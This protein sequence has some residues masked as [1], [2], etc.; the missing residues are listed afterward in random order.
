MNIHYLYS[1]EN[2]KDY[3]TKTIK[4]MY[5]S[6]S[7][8]DMYGGSVMI[9]ILLCFAFFV[10]L[11]LFYVLA[12]MEPI[13]DDW[14]VQRCDPRVIPF[15]GFIN[16]P[17]DS[18]VI[19]YTGDNFNYCIQQILTTITGYALDPLTFITQG[20]EELFQAI[21]DVINSIRTMISNIRTYI[22]DIATEIMQRIANIMVPVQR[23]VIAF[24]D[25]MQKVQG[26]L[27]TGLYTA[28]G[29]YFT[30]K[31]L[32]G[33]VIQLAIVC[34]IILAAF[35]FVMSF[36]PMYW[37]I[38]LT[39]YA[40]YIVIAAILLTIMLFFNI[41]LKIPITSPIPKLMFVLGFINF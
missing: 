1:M 25:S 8:F 23:I 29:S 6:L 22:E 13:K 21:A 20:L 34:L 24:R 11:A 4:K 28:L 16:K 5:E 10:F 27:T 30:L 31:S 9:F 26:V 2:T 32:L 37:P 39:T 19:Q 38:L 18:T 40:F 41:V 36:I 35:I 12:K 7:Y 17:D 33:A 15:A 3:A 14:A